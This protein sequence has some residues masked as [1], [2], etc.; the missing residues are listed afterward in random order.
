MI[1]IVWQ[2]EGVLNAG[3]NQINFR[4]TSS[5]D[6]YSTNAIGFAVNA[7]TPEFEIKKEIVEPKETY[8]VG[9]TITYRVSLKIQK[10]IL[11]R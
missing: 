7:E 3:Q 6:D 8:K 4:T 5:G 11:K 10:L 1:S 2:F 9:E